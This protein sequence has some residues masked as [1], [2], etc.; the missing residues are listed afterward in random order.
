MHG[1]DVRAAR[2]A[3]G[4]SSSTVAIAMRRRSPPRS[5]SSRLASSSPTG[6]CRP[7]SSARTRAAARWLIAAPP[8]C[9]TTSAAAA[10]SS[11][12][13]SPAAGAVTCASRRL[14][15]VRPGLL[16]RVKEPPWASAIDQQRRNRDRMHKSRARGRAG[17]HSSRPFVCHDA[18]TDEIG[19]SASNRTAAREHSD[20]I[21]EPVNTEK[22]APAR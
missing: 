14:N 6:E 5:G 19:A 15:T 2:L 12:R 9:Y 21:A 22:P 20:P 18:R 3:I 8:A 4:R 11:A 1:H 16:S 10:P 7:R 13:A 17:L